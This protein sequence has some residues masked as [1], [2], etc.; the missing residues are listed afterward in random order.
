MIKLLALSLFFVLVVLVDP[1]SGH[2]L[3]YKVTRDEAVIVKVTYANKKAFSL[4]KY[5]IF[6]PDEAIPCLTG[7]TDTEGRIM[8]IPD[9]SGTWRI[10]AYSEDGHGLNISLGTDG[11][12]VF[13]PPEES[14]S[15]NYTG[16]LLGLVIILGLFNL[17]AL[18]LRRKRHATST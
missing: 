10:K 12:E 14:S 8:F 17:Y 11:R 18:F 15:R 5:E 9:S 3:R 4:Q 16:L 6:R 1:A 13:F 2:G 7:R